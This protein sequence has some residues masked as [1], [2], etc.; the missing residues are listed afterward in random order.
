MLHLA[1]GKAHGGI[2]DT[3]LEAADWSWV[4]ERYHRRWLA[5]LKP[6]AIDGTRCFLPAGQALALYVTGSSLSGHAF[7]ISVHLWR[8]RPGSLAAPSAAVGLYPPMNDTD[9]YDTYQTCAVLHVRK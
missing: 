2:I 1:L 8:R 7:D 5:Q 3:H 4:A 9:W 6:L